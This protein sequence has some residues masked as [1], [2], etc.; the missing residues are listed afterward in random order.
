MSELGND[1]DNSKIDN[2]PFFMKQTNVSL[3]D[4][5]VESF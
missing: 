3:T 4:E 5:D 2:V 1:Y